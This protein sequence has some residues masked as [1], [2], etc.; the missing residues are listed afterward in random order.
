MARY[1]EQNGKEKPARKSKQM[2][3]GYSADFRGYIN[4]TLSPEQKAVF[5]EWRLS[6]SLWE[7]YTASVQD[8]V[9]IAVKI[10]PRSEAF[11]A[12]ATQRREASENAGLCVT[13]RARDPVTALER[14][15]FVLAYLSRSE[16][17][18]DIQPLADP[19]RW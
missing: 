10:D 19:D 13:A 15:L 4:V 2:G 6:S 14:L 9:N 12:S 7:T 1:G 11:L 18:E 5:D 8:G 3:D 17:W 16:R